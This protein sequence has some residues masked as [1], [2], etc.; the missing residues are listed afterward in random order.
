[1][2]DVPAKRGRGPDKKPRTRTPITGLNLRHV[3]MRLPVEVIEH[4]D[5]N[6]TKM[7]EV[8]MRYVSYAKSKETI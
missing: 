7:R 8:L 4:F 2:T 6:T 5:G 3:S 1:M